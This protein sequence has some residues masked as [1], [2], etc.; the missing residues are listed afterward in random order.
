[1]DKLTGKM[2]YGIDV[3][4]PGMLNAAI[5]ARAPYSAARWSASTRPPSVSV[6]KGVKKVVQV[7]DNAVAV[8]ADTW[9]EA[10]SALDKAV[11]HL[12]RKATTPRSPVNRSPRC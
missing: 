11:D 7:G 5:K 2:V 4:L 9:W 6:M 8:V 3:K 1:M 10:K 12:G